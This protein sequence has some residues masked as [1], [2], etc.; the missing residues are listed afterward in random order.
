MIGGAVVADA[1]AAVRSR[2][3][4]AAI[5]VA[6]AERA[7]LARGRFA[8]RAAVPALFYGVV[9]LHA[10]CVVALLA[11]PFLA[12]R[13]RDGWFLL[14]LAAVAL[15]WLAFRGECV[16]SW[17]EKA[18]YYERYRLGE[19]PLHCWFMDAYALP[20]VAAFMAA[21]FAVSWAGLARLLL[22]NVVLRPGE[23]GV[24]VRFGA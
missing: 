7:M 15:H 17:A 16:L 23:V 20:G 22:R 6:F 10:A 5:A 21:F 1:V 18:L 4:A 19:A 11:Y 2:A 3:G 9:A 8:R 24:S 12:D 14:L 13:D